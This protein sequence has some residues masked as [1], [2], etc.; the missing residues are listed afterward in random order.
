MPFSVTTRRLDETAVVEVSGDLDLQAAP[1]LAAALAVAR[2]EHRLLVVDLARVEF[3]DSSGLRELLGQAET[4]TAAGRRLLLVPP[5]P[6]AA[7]I[8]DLT[9]TREHFEWVD[10]VPDAERLEALPRR[11]ARHRTALAAI[12]GLV[13]SA[14]LADVARL[15]SDAVGDACVVSRLEG[16]LVHPLVFVHREREAERVLRQR[17]AEPAPVAG[18]AVFRSVVEHGRPVFLDRIDVSELLPAMRSVQEWRGLSAVACLPLGPA[19]RPF[20]LLGCSRDRGRAAYDAEDRNFLERAA[21]TLSTSTTFA[22][23]ASG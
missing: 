18:S 3:I 4:T 20:G 23:A 9:E 15:I 7:R 5:P 6:L 1:A 8:L 11:V 17:L 2:I 10:A 22:V 14:S 13:E 19:D 12:A 16:G 21:H